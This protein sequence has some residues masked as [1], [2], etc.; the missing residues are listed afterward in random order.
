MARA[1]DFKLF[2]PALKAA[3]S[4]ADGAAGGSPPH[5][6]AAVFKTL[7]LVARNRATDAQKGSWSGPDERF[8][9]TLLNTILAVVPR[10]CGSVDV[11]V[12]PPPRPV[13]CPVRGQGPHDEGRARQRKLE[14]PRRLVRCRRPTRRSPGPSHRAAPTSFGARENGSFPQFPKPQ[15]VRPESVPDSAIDKTPGCCLPRPGAP[16]VASRARK[17]GLPLPLLPA[18]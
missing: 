14:D 5:D 6:P 18:P 10:C 3:L 16:L 2:R 15:A 13:Q 7:T 12:E 9:L 11:R 4:D 17:P 8:P 1:V